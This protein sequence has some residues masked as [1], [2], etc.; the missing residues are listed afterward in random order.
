MNINLSFYIRG[1]KY[2]INDQSNLSQGS[3]NFQKNI[4]VHRMPTYQNLF[5]HLVLIN[6]IPKRNKFQRNTD[7]KNYLKNLTRFIPDSHTNFPKT[8]KTHNSKKNKIY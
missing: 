1:T 5:E 6:F 3:K 8:K 2:S 7:S 4:C